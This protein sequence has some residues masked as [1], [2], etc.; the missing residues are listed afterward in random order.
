M[1]LSVKGMSVACAALWG[2]CIL[3]LGIANRALPGYGRAV[4]DLAA[5][6]YPGYDPA[7][8]FGAVIV[9]TLY[10]LVDGAAGGAV[11]AWLYNRAAGHRS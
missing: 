5:S 8:G 1:Q 4:L 11:F 6:V 3:L 10:S 7:G 2:A 9:G